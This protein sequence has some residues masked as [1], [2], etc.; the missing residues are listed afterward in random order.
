MDFYGIDPGK[1]GGIA[2]INGNGQLVLA[3]PMPKREDGWL[4][5]RGAAALLAGGNG[6]FTG[7]N[8][9]YA[10]ERSQSFPKQ[11]AA[12]TARY[13]TDYG[14]LC[15]ILELW[16]SVEFRHYPG[17]RAWKAI[18]EGGTDKAASARLVKRLHPEFNPIRPRAKK[19]HD[20]VCDAIAIA[21]WCRKFVLG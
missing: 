13:M 10:I 9:H 21:H 11:G 15:A 7:D 4:D 2:K 8:A 17:P 19:P 18:L 6:V 5:V 3:V 14:K 16:P 1:N 12:S 20:G